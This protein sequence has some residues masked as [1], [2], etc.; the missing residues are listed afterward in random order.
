M[1]NCPVGNLAVQ[2]TA[3]ELAFLTEASKR[4]QILSSTKKTVALRLGMQMKLRVYQSA[5]LWE[6]VY[7]IESFQ[8]LVV[9]LRGQNYLLNLRLLNMLSLLFLYQLNKILF[10]TLAHNCF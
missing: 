10:K 6:L 7:G 1:S 5:E 2:V 8:N 4:N 9:G 3:D